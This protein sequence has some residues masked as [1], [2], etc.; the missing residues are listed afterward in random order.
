M[1]KEYEHLFIVK[2]S[3]FGLVKLEDSFLTSDNTEF[4]GSLN[5]QS[6]TMEGFKYYEIRHETFALTKLIAMILSGK[7]NLS[8]IK[9]SNIKEFLRKG[10]FDLEQR[11]QNILELEKAVNKLRKKLK[12]EK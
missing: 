1:I 4:R 3:D 5:D 8:K 12:K 7:F 9:D 11:Y 6:L 10:T 2:I